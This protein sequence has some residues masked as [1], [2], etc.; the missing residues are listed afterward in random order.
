V[1]DRD[2]SKKMTVT[3]VTPFRINGYK[4][5]KW[6]ILEEIF[7]GGLVPVFSMV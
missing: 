2:L 5:D 1:I 6:F 4:W 7:L 3:N